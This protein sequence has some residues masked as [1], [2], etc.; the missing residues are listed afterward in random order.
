MALIPKG[1]K[2]VFP[3]GDGESYAT[4][5]EP[6]NE[7]LNEYQVTKLDGPEKAT[8]C[9]RSMH[10]KTCQGKFFDLLVIG[11]V[12]LEDEKGPVTLDRLDVIPLSWKSEVVFRR[13]DR[14]P[15]DVQGF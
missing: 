15:V 6:T 1:A 14:V 10:Y 2:A 13:W 12:G 5:R 8:D 4:L 7:E 9:E 3:V 11:V